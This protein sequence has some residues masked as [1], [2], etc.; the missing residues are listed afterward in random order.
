MNRVIIILVCL[1]SIASPIFS[2]LEENEQ[3]AG[4]GF[5]YFG[6]DV[7]TIENK[8]ALF[9]G[10]G[11][12]FIIKNFTVGVFFSGLNSP[13]LKTDTTN[14]TYKLAYSYGGLEFNYT[15]RKSKPLNI[16]SGLKFSI[17]QTRMLDTYYIRY[18]KRTTYGINPQ[19]GIQ[20]S[21][22]DFFKIAFGVQYFYTYFPKSPV[23]YSPKDF[24]SPG[25]FLTFKLGTFKN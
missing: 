21:V 23:L 2:Q 12:G 22:S 10:G 15:F 3:Y 9:L 8:P 20:Y 14:T 25:V 24:S 4:E 18:G 7:R 5:G 1:I 13:L 19:F 6:L 16:F 11:G 17:G